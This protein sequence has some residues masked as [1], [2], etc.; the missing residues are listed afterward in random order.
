MQTRSRLAETFS[1]VAD[2]NLRA[3]VAQLVQIHVEHEDSGS[4]PITRLRN[5]VEAYASQYGRR[6]DTT[7]NDLPTVGGL[8]REEA[9]EH[10]RRH[11][12]AVTLESISLCNFGSYRESTTFELHPIGRR[13]VT[14]VVGGNGDGKSTLFFALNWALYGNEFL[15]QLQ[16]EKQRRLEDLVNREA[17]HLAG[18]G[19]GSVL[20]EVTLHFSVRGTRYYVVRAAT[21]RVTQS[22]AGV[23]LVIEHISTKLRK[24]DASGNH[25][26]LLESAMSSLLRGLPSH[27][28]DFYLFDGERINRF[29]AAGSQTLI[30]R[31][32]RRVMGIEALEKT[33]D[34]VARVAAPFRKAAR[35]QST[36]ELMR[37]RGDLDVRQAEK[38]DARKKLED[39]E[40]ELVDLR[41][42][43]AQ[44]EDHLRSTP[45]TRP[46]QERRDGYE[47]QIRQANQDEERAVYEIR[48]LAADASLLM[49]ADAVSKLVA[50]LDA[51]RQ[52]GVIPGPISKQLLAD[53]LHLNECICG[54]SLAPSTTARETLE[55]RLGELTK[56]AEN[57]ELMLNLFYELASVNAQ[58]KSRAES[59]DKRRADLA[60]LRKRRT[61]VKS[62]LDQVA[63]ELEGIAIVNR[64]DWEQERTNTLRRQLQTEASIETA[65]ERLALLEKDI[66]A[67]RSSEQG[68]EGS[69]AVASEAAI[70]RDWAEAAEEALRNVFRE[71]AAV[72]RVEVKDATERLWKSM[73]PSVAEYSV[74][75]TDA[76][77]LLAFDEYGHPSMHKLAMGQQQC[78]GLAFITAVAQVA[79]SRPPLVIDM[80]FGRLDA[81]VA[82]SVAASL[83]SLTE[84]LV[85]FVLPET[86]W[87]ERTKQAISPHLAREYAIAYDPRTSTTSSVCIRSTGGAG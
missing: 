80:P 1:R 75:V 41:S 64:S 51:D 28:R 47:A 77:E 84:Q 82:A 32:I 20:T 38:A 7:F 62:A 11:E 72:A 24:I 58:I 9:G 49:S 65:K 4:A 34:E 3:L 60:R 18:Q 48:D 63:T 70:K 59:M 8:S 35:D 87:S 74:D 36:G 17:V 29:V 45:D 46:L 57:S 50:D 78:L 31:A 16:Q 23:R 14:A 52:A 53:L 39:S 10:S 13:N 40:A 25:S 86:E 27:V 30:R 83:P 12:A 85:L 76:F 19:G 33:A 69:Q 21:S 71:F 37:I 2:E 55:A 73:L 43:V 68:L 5:A 6:L 79:E 44:L 54:T 67:L 56:Q 66:E 81:A 15:H 26:E 61:E 42:R 22:E